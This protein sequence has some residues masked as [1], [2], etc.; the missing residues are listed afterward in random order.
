MNALPPLLP[1]DWLAEHLDDPDILIVDVGRAS[2]YMQLHIPGSLHLE[3]SNLVS[4]QQPSVGER[5][6]PLRLSL[7]LG[8]L[9]LTPERAVVAY[10]DEGGANAA[11]LLWLLD[12]VGHP[13]SLSLLDGG[14]HAWANEDFPTEA[15]SRVGQPTKYAVT[16]SERG[17]A[18]R[19]YVESHLED[20]SV[21]LLDARSPAEYDGSARSSARAGHIPGAI[22]YEWTTPLDPDRNVRLR[23]LDELR[24]QLASLG[25]SK[26]KEIIT[27]CQTH[28]RS[29]HSYWLLRCLGYRKVR[30]YA[31]S[32]AEW[33]N[34]DDTPIV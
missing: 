31:G 3:Y 16:Y 8:G 2:T 18:D 19:H 25:L 5:P 28:H 17:Y 33:G 14:L 12:T 7:A 9:G 10:D 24:D 13:G 1:P 6:E 11:R 34:L 26:D 21:A 4:G 27:Y 32:W 23:D 15:R 22:N 20:A 30:G 29:S